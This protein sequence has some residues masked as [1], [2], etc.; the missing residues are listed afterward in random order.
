MGSDPRHL[1]LALVTFLAMGAGIAVNVLYLQD[2][3]GASPAERARTSRAQARLAAERQRQLAIEPAQ[4]RAPAARPDGRQPVMAANLARPATTLPAAT[5][6]GPRVGRFAVPAAPKADGPAAVVDSEAEIVRAVQQ[7]LAA[8]GYEP[9]PATGNAA[10]LT[11]GAIMAYEHDQRL[12]VTGEASEPLL[13]LLENAPGAREA[14]A[15]R[16][17]GRGHPHAQQ[18]IQTVQQSLASLGY[19]TARADGLPGEM[20]ERAIREY[21]MDNGMIPTG[22]VSSPLLSR[23]ARAPVSR[24]TAGTQ[25]SQPR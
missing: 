4:P 24:R 21:E 6:Q 5:E 1:R 14:L 7:R 25:R 13:R 16:V 10:L 12:P 2:R 11:R 19:F 3:G 8:L 17:P 23:L 15:L 22:R 20:L 18:V 9:G